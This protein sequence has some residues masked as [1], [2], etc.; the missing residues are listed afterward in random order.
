M[1]D[2]DRIAELQAEVGESGIAEIVSIFL[3][4]VEEG[5][6]QL[7]AMTDGNQISEKLH[8]LKGSAQNI[9]LSEFSALCLEGEMAVRTDPTLRPDIPAIRSALTRAQAEL[10]EIGG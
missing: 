5:V 8:F 10:A 7:A 1:I 9:G 6:D 4:E 2:W 3:E